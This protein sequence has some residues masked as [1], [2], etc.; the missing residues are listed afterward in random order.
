M[1]VIISDDTVEKAARG[2]AA[3][4]GNDSGSIWEHMK[5]VYLKEAR[6]AL[7]AALE[8]SVAVPADPD[9][10]DLRLCSF[11]Y[12]ADEMRRR[13][14]TVTPAPHGGDFCNG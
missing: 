2:I 11:N 8:G 3:L 14:A 6:A 12:L 9:M 4:V 10:P 7:T 13:G 1:T 5:P